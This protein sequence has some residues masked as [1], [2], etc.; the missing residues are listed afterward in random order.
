MSLESEAGAVNGLRCHFSKWPSY[1]SFSSAVDACQLLPQQEKDERVC[2]C[3]GLWAED[4]DRVRAN[5]EKNPSKN[6]D[7]DGGEHACGRFERLIKVII[8]SCLVW[9]LQA[10]C[11]GGEG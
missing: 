10:V 8:V 4:A 2:V 1:G 6:K 11:C 7:S 3:L 5:A 9:S